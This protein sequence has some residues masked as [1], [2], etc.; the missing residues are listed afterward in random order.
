MLST[1]RRG[2]PRLDPQQPSVSVSVKLTAT[3]YD[4]VYKRARLARVSVP[5]IIRRDNR[6][7]AREEQQRQR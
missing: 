5:E 1:R 2:R 6:A 4:A 7:A 3:Q